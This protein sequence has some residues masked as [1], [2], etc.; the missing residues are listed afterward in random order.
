MVVVSLELKHYRNF[1][2]SKVEFSPGVNIFYGDNA[3]GKTNLLESIYLCGTSRSHRGSKDRELIQFGEEEAHIRLHF[4]KDLLSHR[5]DVH[6]KKRKSKGIAVDGVPLR[7]SGDLLGYMHIIFFSPEDLSII[8]DGPSGRRKFLDMEMSQLDK[9]Y[10][11]HLVRYHKIL[12]ERNNLLKQ[13]SRF[14]ALLDTLDGWDAQLLESGRVIIG[15]RAAFVEELDGMMRQ[16]HGQLT[17]QKEEIKIIY[18]NNT[19]AE[20]FSRLLYEQRQ[21]DIN[22]GT[23]SVGPH[24]DDLQFQSNG[25]DLRRFGSQGQQ[26][27]AALSLKLSEIRMVEKETGDKPILLLDDVL[28]ELDGHRQAW[29]L[30]SIR[31]IQTMI[32]CTGLE[33]LVSSRID[34]DQVFHVVNGNVK[35]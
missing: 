19:T 32:S 1:E 20:D 28:S 13:I 6:L 24:R 12:S 15:K 34:I 33:D 17:G 29:L 2:S 31:D 30:E 23:T 14:P 10:L 22:N 3:Q 27:T 8:K 21:K 11:T 35:I 9:V 16:I 25:M 18:E 5:L 26:R 4:S 7:R